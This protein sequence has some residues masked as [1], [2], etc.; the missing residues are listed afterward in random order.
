MDQPRLAGELREAFAVFADAGDKG[1]RFRLACETNAVE[2]AM[3]DR[4]RLR[5]RAP[6][7]IKALSPRH[8]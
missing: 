3:E 2:L 8:P 4:F 6:M 5:D 7:R 1:D